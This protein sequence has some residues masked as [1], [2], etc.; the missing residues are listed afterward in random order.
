MKRE[1]ELYVHIPFCQRKCAYCDFLSFTADEQTK[2]HYID[3]LLEEIGQWQDRGDYSVST[4]FFGGGTPSALAGEQIAAV[5]EKIK[6]VFALDGD[7]EITVEC[8]PGTLDWHKLTCYRACGVNRLSL[9]LQS[10]REEELKT[11]GRIHT[12][13]EFLESYELARR[14]GFS[15]INVDLMSALPGQSAADWEETLRKVLR[16]Q[17]EHISAYSLMIEEG[18]PFYELYAEEDQKRAAGEV[19]TL[20]PSEEE[21]RR[22]YRLTR[23]LLFE[24]GYRRY[25]ISNYARPGFACRHNCGYWQRKEY[26]G[27]GLGAASLLGNV[28]TSNTADLKSYLRGEREGACQ[29]L[30]RAEEMEETMFLGLR[31]EEGVSREAFRERFGCELE[32]VYKEALEKLERQG[33]L[34]KERERVYLTE[35]GIDVSNYAL[36]EFLF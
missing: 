11:L 32:A 27:F 6:S 34:K 29:I 36:S 10:A 24:H 18:T 35:R 31:M 9:G 23:R 7:A 14:A 21:E 12:Y 30:K 17:P 19:C 22:M 5:M 15:N 4:V 20:L 28:R 3:A 25:E 26:K 16:L 13:R 2:Q 1:L 33:L 8:N